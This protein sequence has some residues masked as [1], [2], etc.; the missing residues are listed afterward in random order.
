MIETWTKWHFN[1]RIVTRKWERER[2]WKSDV[3]SISIECFYGNKVL[4]V[5]YVP[6]ILFYKTHSPASI[7]SIA[8]TVLT[9][10]KFKRINSSS[11][12]CLIRCASSFYLLLFSCGIQS[13]ER[14]IWLKWRFAMSL[15]KV[16]LSHFALQRRARF[17]A[18]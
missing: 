1:F 7:R 10:E 8:G 13:N 3:F 11:L 17:C 18:V 2:I 6:K 15:L 5:R 4:F 16:W 12:E 14:I 9:S